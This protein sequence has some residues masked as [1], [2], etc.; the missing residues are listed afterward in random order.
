MNAIPLLWLYGASSV[1]KST[2]GWE[3]FTRPAPALH[4][5]P[6]TRHPTPTSYPGR[7]TSSNNHFIPPS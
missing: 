1:G 2:L 3:L 4:Q 5:S 7:T 6:A